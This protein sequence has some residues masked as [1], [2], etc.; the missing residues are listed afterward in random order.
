M[1]TPS[2]LSRF[3]QY[4]HDQL[5]VANAPM[6]E[7]ALAQEGYRPDILSDVDQQA[8]VAC[9]LTSGDAIHLKCGAQSWWHGPDAKKPKVANILPTP[10]SAGWDEEENQDYGIRF[11]KRYCEGGCK[12]Y[13]M[14]HVVPGKKRGH[15]EFSFLVVLQH[16][17]S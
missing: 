7:H 10:M 16:S 12:S 9:G 14:S 3:L 4:A 5:G 6:F 15:C 8:L 17:H 13:F 11:E 2:K 1:N